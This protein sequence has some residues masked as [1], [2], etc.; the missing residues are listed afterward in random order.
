ML[1]VT[2]SMID[3]I[4]QRIKFISLID[5]PFFTLLLQLYEFISTDFYQTASQG[6]QRHCASFYGN[7]ADSLNASTVQEIL[8]SCSRSV[9]G[10]LGISLKFNFVKVLTGTLQNPNRQGSFG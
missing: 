10:Q 3:S 6:L 9:F 1:L 7:R 2:I 4:S 8:P 5:Y